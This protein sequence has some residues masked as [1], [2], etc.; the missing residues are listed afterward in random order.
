VSQRLVAFVRLPPVGG[1]WLRGLSWRGRVV[2]GQN[3][4]LRR[5][6]GFSRWCLPPRSPFMCRNRRTRVSSGRVVEDDCHGTSFQVRCGARLD[7]K[8]S[9][10]NPWAGCRRA[11]TSRQERQGQ[12]GGRR[13]SCHSLKAYHQGLFFDFHVE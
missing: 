2:V 13:V 11:Q 1:F 8:V 12:D 4:F 7:V 9:E 5:A 3:L 6:H 10:Q